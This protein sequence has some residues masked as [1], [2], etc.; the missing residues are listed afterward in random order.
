MIALG[1]HLT[2]NLARLILLSGTQQDHK[3]IAT[4]GKL[5]LPKN[6]SRDDVEVFAQAFRSLCAVHGIDRVAINRRPISG[7]GAGGAA[8]FITEGVLLATSPCPI[9]FIHPSTMRATDRKKPALKS[10]KPGTVDLG[11]AYDLAFEALP[12]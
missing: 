11:K 12:E 8:T 2:S 10:T 7:Q 4:A 9:N 5:A 3:I 6:P 1:V